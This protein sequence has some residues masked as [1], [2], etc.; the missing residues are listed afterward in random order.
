MKKLFSLLIILSSIAVNAVPVT[1]LVKIP[2]DVSYSSTVGMN[3]FAKGNEIVIGTDLVNIVS[4]DE[5][6]GLI[7]LHEAHHISL[8]HS[9][10]L[11]QGMSQFCSTYPM[12]TQSDVNNCISLY[13]FTYW[14][15]FQDMEREADMGAFLV[16]KEIGYS[17][18]SC[19]I[20]IKLLVR[21]GESGGHGTTH[22][23]LSSRYEV[24]TKV[25]NGD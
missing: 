11:S 2:Y 21:L 24:C 3:A 16:A 1:D 18:R 7:I 10:R 6:L 17:A 12:N 5:E 22:P 14:E 25:L 20:L 13:K 4:S 19:N 9:E 23:S 15:V 8:R